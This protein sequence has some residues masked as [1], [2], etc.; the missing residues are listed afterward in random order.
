MKIAGISERVTTEITARR[1]QLSAVQWRIP[2]SLL[3]TNTSEM[4]FKTRGVVVKIQCRISSF[5]K[6]P[7]TVGDWTKDSIKKEAREAVNEAMA[8]VRINFVIV[9]SRDVSSTTQKENLDC[10]PISC[11]NSA[12]TRDVAVLFGSARSSGSR[13]SG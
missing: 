8:K 11:S 1:V 2:D 4:R 7:L 5:L 6:Y 13:S 9:E 12:I 3:E 10:S